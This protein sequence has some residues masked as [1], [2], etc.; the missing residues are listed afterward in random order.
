MCTLLIAPAV[1]AEHFLAALDGMD[2]SSTEGEGR[3][4]LYG[5]CQPPSR[6]SAPGGLRACFFAARWFLCR[7]RGDSAAG[8]ASA[9]AAAVDSIDVAL[10]TERP[11][12]H[13]VSALLLLSIISLFEGGGEAATF[14]GLAQRLG[15]FVQGLCP[16]IA[17]SAALFP[18]KT[19]S[20]QKRPHEAVVW[21]PLESP[22]GSA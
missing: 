21:P 19:A 1:D 5:S 4:T 20:V 15:G 2:L 8:Q 11:S 3:V 12:Q 6:A 16:S 18:K 10:A 14:A 9:F 17:F 13:L 7:M 22:I